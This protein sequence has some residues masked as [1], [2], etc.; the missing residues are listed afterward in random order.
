MSGTSQARQN[1]EILRIFFQQRE[2]NY[3][4]RL[5]S[6]NPQSSPSESY[7]SGA[8]QKKK[9]KKKKKL[10]P[11]KVWRFSVEPCCRFF[12]VGLSRLDKACGIYQRRAFSSLA[13]AWRQFFVVPCGH[14]K[15][16]NPVSF[17]QSSF[18]FA[19]VHFVAVTWKRITAKSLCSLFM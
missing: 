5:C 6:Q 10:I 7:I 3:Y 19:F 14:G 1:V 11:P 17:N 15:N 9:R 4:D 13:G 8:H 16:G 12:S 18:R 2:Q